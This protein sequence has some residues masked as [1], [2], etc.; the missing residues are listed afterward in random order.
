M[1]VAAEADF[2]SRRAIFRTNQASFVYQLS[3]RGR[4]LN[5]EHRRAN[6][7]AAG[8]ELSGKHWFPAQPSTSGSP[9]QR[10]IRAIPRRGRAAIAREFSRAPRS[11]PH[12]SVCDFGPDMSIDMRAT[13]FQLQIIFQLL[14]QRHDQ[15]TQPVQETMAARSKSLLKLFRELDRL[16]RALQCRELQREI[17]LVHGKLRA[18]PNRSSE[19]LPILRL[20]KPHQEHRYLRVLNSRVDPQD[21]SIDWPRKFPLRAQSC[22]V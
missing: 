10:T 14:F 4:H 6:S 15:K 11:L 12:L 20:Q 18:S 9:S 17:S 5:R 13:F 16:V 21:Q 22:C 1:T 7:K 3:V 2:Q 19:N 8:R